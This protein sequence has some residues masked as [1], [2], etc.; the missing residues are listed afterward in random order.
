MISIPSPVDFIEYHH[1]YV[2]HY[3]MTVPKLTMMVH[4]MA[5]IPKANEVM[6]TKPPSTATNIAMTMKVCGPW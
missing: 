5:G 2:I 1:L 6:F 4:T 3:S